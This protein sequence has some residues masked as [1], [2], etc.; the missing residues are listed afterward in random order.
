M[1]IH[2]IKAKPLLDFEKSDTLKTYRLMKTII[3]GFI[4]TLL[5]T[6][7]QVDP[8][9]D[10][11][12][13]CEMCGFWTINVKDIEGGACI[14]AFIEF[15]RKPQRTSDE[16]GFELQPG[17]RMIQHIPNRWIRMKTDTIDREG[18][19]KQQGDSLFIEMTDHWSN[20]VE[21]VKIS[22]HIVR[23]PNNERVLEHLL[24]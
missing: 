21:V 15:V 9:P 3:L 19:W 7:C 10:S 4:L 11:A 2:P 18:I 24:P 1:I 8:V 16:F 23:Q 6:S 5:G 12:Q 22:Y 20:P 13:N 14:P 17:G